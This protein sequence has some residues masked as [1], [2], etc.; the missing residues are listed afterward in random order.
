MAGA[1]SSGV[2]AMTALA[3]SI[4]CR[5]ESNTA[6]NQNRSSLIV[7]CCTIP[8]QVQPEGSRPPQRVF[9]ETF[10]DAE[11]V[12]A[13]SVQGGIQQAGFILHPEIMGPGQLRPRRA[14]APT[15][16]RPAVRTCSTTTG[17]RPELVTVW[18]WDCG[19]VRAR[20]RL[21]GLEAILPSRPRTEEP[22]EL[23]TSGSLPPTSR[24]STTWS[25]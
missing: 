22:W 6:R 18:D 12:V 14:A 1:A 4:S 11:H 7:R 23:M 25:S 3:S 13:L 21:I 9:W 24:R 19:H 15:W 20:P 17:V 10:E 5:Y 16:L 2:L 8:R